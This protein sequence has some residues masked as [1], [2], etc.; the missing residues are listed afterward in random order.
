MFCLRCGTEIPQDAD[1]C[2]K[3]GSRTMAGVESARGI[4]PSTQSPSTLA[5]EP[6]A[7]SRAETDKVGVGRYILSF[8]LA[9]LIGVAITFSLRNHGWLS[10]WI[11][12]PIF[13]I[14]IILIAATAG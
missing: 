3:C 5:S 11:C 9:G 14:V 7:A 8:C 2:H 12:L 6:T 4:N 13:V 1:F 10:T